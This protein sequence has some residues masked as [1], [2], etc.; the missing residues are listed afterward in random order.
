[1]L[2]QNNTMGYNELYRSVNLKFYVSE[3]SFDYHIKKLLSLNLIGKKDSLVRGKPVLYF[4]TTAGKRQLQMKIVKIKY[5]NEQSDSILKDDERRRIMLYFV[6]FIMDTWVKEYR[7]NKYEFDKFLSTLNLKE[8]D[9]EIKEKEFYQ[10]PFRNKKTEFGKEKRTI[11]KTP[12]HLLESVDDEYTDFF[13]ITKLD[14]FSYTNKQIGPPDF[15][16]ID[17]YQITY[18]LDE[19]S[20]PE[21]VY[22][23]ELPGVSKNDI[24]YSDERPIFEHINFTLDEV[25]EIIDLAEKEGVIKALKIG[26]DIRYVLSDLNLRRFFE[27]LRDFY[28]LLDGYV[29]M[30]WLTRKPKKEEIKWM[31]LFGGDKKTDEIRKLTYIDRHNRSKTILHNR[32]KL[33]VYNQ[34]LGI[35][36]Y[37]NKLLR[38]YK[39]VKK[40]ELPLY[41]LLEMVYP[42]VLRLP[43]HQ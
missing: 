19:D 23:C 31:N 22:E 6:L 27:D 10:L 3:G 26:S 24:L 37:Y 4:L 40:M 5:K 7:F 16:H 11:Y 8:K 15:G 39:K 35:Q 38:K 43:N 14:Y 41:E 36:K 25:E 1:L 42:K 12:N 18:L 13:S 2:Q 20:K 34:E 32:K 28:E 17:E 30:I 9:L 21:T 29:W 33:W